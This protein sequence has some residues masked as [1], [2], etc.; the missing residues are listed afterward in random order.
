[1]ET[2]AKSAHTP[3]FCA[4][5][6]FS[7]GDRKPSTPMTTRPRSAVLLILAIIALLAVTDGGITAFFVF[8]KHNG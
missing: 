7:F 5:D 8:R 1:V 3:I 4:P 6:E 2:S